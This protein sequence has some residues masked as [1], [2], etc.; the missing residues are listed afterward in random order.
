MLCC[1]LCWCVLVVQCFVFFVFEHMN[2]DMDKQINNYHE[3]IIIM[4]V[5]ASS[6]P[7]SQSAFQPPWLA[8]WLWLAGWV[9]GI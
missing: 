8:G 5:E 4:V 1:N 6:H 2:K 9:G 3:L 7:A